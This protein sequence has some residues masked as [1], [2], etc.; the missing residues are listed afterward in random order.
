VNLA[1]TL[2]A[3]GGVF[4]GGG[5]APRIP[6]FLAKS[7]SAPALRPKDACRLPGTI[8]TVLITA[9]NPALI[10]CARAFSDPSPRVRRADQAEVWHLGVPATYS[11]RLS[12]YPC[13]TAERRL[14]ASA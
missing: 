8:A 1:L 5:I 14:R 6:E 4:I 3:R 7:H 12:R 11:Q 13:A 2:G 10:G 9:H